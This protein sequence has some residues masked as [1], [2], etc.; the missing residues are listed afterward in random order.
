[1]DS[2][3]KMLYF[4]YEC[5]GKNKKVKKM[6]DITKLNQNKS[7]QKTNIYTRKNPSKKS[8]WWIVVIIIVVVVVGVVDSPLLLP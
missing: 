7:K 8:R 2:I 4:C 3:E 6:S 5:G 1:M